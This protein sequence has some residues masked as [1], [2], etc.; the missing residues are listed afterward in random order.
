VIARSLARAGATP[1]QV[2]IA[3]IGFALLSGFSFWMAN[4]NARGG[5]PPWLVLGAIGIQL[6]LLCNMID[7]LLAIE[8]GLQTPTGDLYNEIPDRVADILILV[9]AGYSIQ[10]LPWGVT[11]GWVAAT[12]AVFTA[13]VRVFGGSLGLK[14][15]FAGPMAKQ[16]RMFTLSV[17]AV[18]GAIEFAVHGTAWSVSAALSL[19]IVG[20]ALTVMRRIGRIATA[21]QGR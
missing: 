11:L 7:G 19:I 3:G 21:R 20:S 15:D 17:G 6:R 1:N 9:G 12:L 18:A 16:H 14:Q 5:P 10:R 2:S 4:W 8:C 13:Y